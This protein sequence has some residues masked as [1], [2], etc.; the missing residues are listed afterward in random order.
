V[1]YRPAHL[2]IDLGTLGTQALL[3]PRVHLGIDR[4]I[5]LSFSIAL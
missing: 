5:V 3:E 1:T 4:N 2:S